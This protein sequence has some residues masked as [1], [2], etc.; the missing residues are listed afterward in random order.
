MQTLCMLGGLLSD[1]FL[2][3]HALAALLAGA[4]R[5]WDCIGSPQPRAPADG[6][7]LEAATTAPPPRWR[8]T[9]VVAAVARSG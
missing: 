6:G 2:F 1:W 3:R 4:L 8:R 9:S 5:M 7:A